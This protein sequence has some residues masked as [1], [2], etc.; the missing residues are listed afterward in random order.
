VRAAIPYDCAD[1]GGREAEKA[2]AVTSDAADV[3]RSEAM[4]E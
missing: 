1:G 3:D 2:K 4:A